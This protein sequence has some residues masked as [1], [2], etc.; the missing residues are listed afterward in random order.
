MS[1]GLT[2]LGALSLGNRL[3]RISDSL[4]YQGSRVYQIAGANFEPRWF[5][6]YSYLYRHGPTAITELAKGLGVSHPGINKIGNELI[7]ARLV[8]PYRDRND[9]RKRLLALTTI[10]RDRYQN[11]EPIWREIR[12]SLQSLLDDAG[13]DF[14]KSLTALESSFATED[15]VERFEKRWH[16]RRRQEILIRDYR[17]EY[18]DAFRTLNEAWISQYFELQESDTKLL[19]NP[20][21]CIVDQG[22]DVLFA[23][24]EFSEEVV[25]T[26]AL[27]RRSDDLIEL[28]YMTVASEVRGRKIGMKLGETAIS[29]S[30]ELGAVVVCIYANRMLNPAITLYSGLGF[31]EKPILGDRHDPRADVYMELEL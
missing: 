5:P 9:K 12:Q 31:K 29:R 15:F 11:L 16:G 4:L 19:Q 27:L 7:E 13:G 17:R 23:V 24:D 30:R 6:A 26:V 28:G 1:D 20:Y 8:A 10:G 3:K 2:E 21:S 18:D 22:D 14:L 25:G